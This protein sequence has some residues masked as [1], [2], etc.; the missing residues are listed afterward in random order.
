MIV[1]DTSELK[2]PTQRKL[3]A[4][5]W[6]LQKQRV[7]AP[8]A[9]ARELAPDGVQSLELGGE[10]PAERALRTGLGGL[11]PTRVEQLRQQVWW[12]QE[13]RNP[14]SPYEVVTLSTAQQRM[15]DDI[16]EEIDP[17]CFP[18]TDSD[19]IVDLPDARIVAESL[20]IGAK[21]LF[22]SNMR[23]IDRV[24][25]NEWAIANGKRLGFK[26]EDVLYPAD[27]TLVEWTRSEEGLERWIQAGLL[28]CWPR[29]D[30]A[31]PRDVIHATRSGIEA[32]RRGTGG[33]LVA[34]AERLLNGIEQHPNPVALV[35]R[36]RA[37]FP[38]PTVESDRRHP[39]YSH[40]PASP[41]R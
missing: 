14:S 19:D 41:G 6:E 27:A 17:R 7:R 2:R 13:W 31:K 21:M 32:M 35:E 38:S 1:V 15:V 9:V 22:T 34:A 39:T 30:Q 25:V 16:L 18:R 5:W 4:A 28:A 33:K 23:T 3:H 8:L 29:N 20:A 24:E 12:V 36:T 10:S 40:G 26:P 37:T 11:S